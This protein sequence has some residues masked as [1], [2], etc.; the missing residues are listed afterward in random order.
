MSLKGKAAAIGIAELKPWKEP[1]PDITPLNLMGR[2]MVE[3]IADAGLEKKDIDGFLV[4][5]PVADPGF[6]YPASAAEVLGLNPRV[7]NIVDIGGASPAGMIWRAAAA[8]NAG[9]AEA[10][11]CIVA[12]LNKMGDQKVPTISVQREFEAPYG[13]I[14]ANCGYAMIANRHMYE[15][16]TKPARWRKLPWTSAPTPSKIRWPPSM[17]RPSPSTTS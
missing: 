11:L 14:G 3:A 6:I 16:G 10:V 12:D 1:P 7:L 2:L 4:G 13:N 15:Y 5:M 17:T 9:M 8:I